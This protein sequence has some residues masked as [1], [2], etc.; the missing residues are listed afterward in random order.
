MEW[1][2]CHLPILCNTNTMFYGTTALF[3]PTCFPFFGPK[4]LVFYPI[5]FLT[6]GFFLPVILVQLFLFGFTT[7]FLDPKYPLTQIFFLIK[8]NLLL[9]TLFGAIFRLN[10]LFN[11]KNFWSNS[12]IKILKTFRS[13][14]IVQNLQSQ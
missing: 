7:F 8:I 5:L 14:K 3:R 2:P 10:I 11:Q 4:N 9:Q 13:F 12:F 1:T 6:Q